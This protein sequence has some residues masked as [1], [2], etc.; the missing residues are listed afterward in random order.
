MLRFRGLVAAAA[1]AL[2]VI[3]AAIACSGSGSSDSVS[4]ITGVTVRAE[5]VTGGKGCGRGATQVFKYAV[6][7]RRIPIAPDAS[8]IDPVEDRKKGGDEVASNV[9]DC[10]TDATFVELPSDENYYGRYVLDVYAFNETAYVAAG[11]DAA[12]RQAAQNYNEFEKR[13][14]PTWKTTCLAEQSILVQAVANSCDPLPLATPDASAAKTAVTL[15]L[16]SFAAGDGKTIACDVDY[17]RVFYRYMVNG[18]AR[19]ETVDIPCLG[20]G[21]EAKP[22]TVTVTPAAAPATYLF[23][24]AVVKGDGTKLGETTCTATTSPGLTT[25]ATCAPIP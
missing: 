1:T 11:G 9:Y 22:V 6:I 10:F 4:P 23:E 24:V 17:A 8:P 20:L 3:A 19:T 12:V 16:A 5:T 15:S 2:S 7:V 21:E 18:G 13:T 14:N 25:P